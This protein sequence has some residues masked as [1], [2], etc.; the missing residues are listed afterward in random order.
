MASAD[1]TLE[2]LVA[3]LIWQLKETGLLPEEELGVE[4]DRNVA[5]FAG[6]DELD[7]NID[8]G[9]RFYIRGVTVLLRE[10]FEDPGFNASNY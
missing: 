1:N 4:P 10:P 3:A 8:T 7:E 2:S 6:D 9:E 5:V